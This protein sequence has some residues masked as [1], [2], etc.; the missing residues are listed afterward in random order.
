MTRYV[1]G[2]D[3]WVDVAS[4][5]KVE[6]VGPFIRSDLPAYVS[7]VTGKPVEG[8][9]A[10]REDLKRSGSRE[11]DPSEFKPVYRNPEFAKKNGLK[12]GGDPI[13][14]P[15]RLPTDIGA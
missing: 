14:P 7:P 4:L 13:A 1:W 11:V 10:R 15:K 6:R 3:D 9:A 12:L 8:R 5:P 2:G